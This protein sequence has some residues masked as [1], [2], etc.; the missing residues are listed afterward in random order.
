MCHYI[1]TLAANFSSPVS[2]PA[3]IFAQTARATASM[4]SV[5]PAVTVSQ[6]P[7][8]PL[9][10]PSARPAAIRPSPLRLPAAAPPAVPCRTTPRRSAL[11]APT[12]RRARGQ[13]AA[14]ARPGGPESVHAAPISC[15]Q[16]VTHDPSREDF[17]GLRATPERPRRGARA[18]GRGPPA[19][20]RLGATRGGEEPDRPTGRRQPSCRRP[21][22]PVAGSSTSKSCRPRS[23][24]SKRRSISWCSTER[25]AS[26]SCPRAHR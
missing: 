24:G 16:E 2:S 7:A 5:E 10:T 4:L 3:S 8:R 21:T 23:R 25:S 22:I 13:P 17:R 14:R 26:T 9:A 11:A 12:G 19:D 18:P 1:S 20:H 15:H 6:H